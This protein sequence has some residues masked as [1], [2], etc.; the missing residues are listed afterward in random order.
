M[1]S[2][3]RPQLVVPHPPDNHGEHELKRCLQY[4]QHFGIF[5]ARK[6]SLGQGNMFTGVCL[7]TGGVPGRGDACSRGGACSW[8]VS[9]LGV[10][11]PGG[12]LLWGDACSRRACSG[13]VPAP[14]EVPALVGG[15]LRGGAWWKPPPRWPL[16]RAVRIPL[17]CILAIKRNCNVFFQLRLEPFLWIRKIPFS[18]AYM[19][20]VSEDRRLREYRWFKLKLIARVFLAPQIEIEIPASDWDKEYSRYVNWR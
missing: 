8:G 18:R 2:R 15:V 13:G 10:P 7:S 20:M 17:E 3:W 16:L 19:R 12:G 4:F 5:T 6:R 11:A 1:S 14:G 9:A